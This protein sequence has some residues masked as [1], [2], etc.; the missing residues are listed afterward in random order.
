M[1]TALS[2]TE[3]RAGRADLGSL[4][5]F[6]RSG[7]TSTAQRRMRAAGVLLLLMTGLVVLAPA[8]LGG[9]EPRPR[10]GQVLAVMPSMC[11]AFLVL[12]VITAVAS[13]GGREVIGRAGERSRRIA[14]DEVAAA[15]PSKKW[16]T[17]ME[18]QIQDFT[19]GDESYK[20]LFGAQPSPMWSVTQAGSAAGSVALFALKQAPWI[21]LAAKRMTGFKL[22]PASIST[23]AR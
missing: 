19:I 9:Q 6:R 14:W 10:S 23:G 1:S 11:L 21:K 18:S 3:L 15:D 17:K 7:L 13:A 20:R 4:L 2:W 5:E 22:L 12:S 8:Y 16:T